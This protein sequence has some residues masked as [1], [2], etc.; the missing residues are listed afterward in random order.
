MKSLKS[1]SNPNDNNEIENIKNQRNLFRTAIAIISSI[2]F[3]SVVIYGSTQR[4]ELL[5]FGIFSTVSWMVIRYFELHICNEDESSV[6]GE[7]VASQY[8]EG[9]LKYVHHH[10]DEEHF[11]NFE[12]KY[13]EVSGEYKI[14]DRSLMILIPSSCNFPKKLSRKENGFERVQETFCEIP[15][16]IPGKSPS[17]EYTYRKPIKLDVHKVYLDFLAGHEVKS[18]MKYVLFNF[19]MC[20]KSC[21]GKSH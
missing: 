5:S 16:S 19:P 3:N 17:Q 18:Q 21:I 6:I 11:D 14:Q 13:P 9:F 12:K 2:S 1:I 8:W 10:L 7:R 15:V 4:L 20:L